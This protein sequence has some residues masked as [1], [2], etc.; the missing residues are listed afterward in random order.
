[1]GKTIKQVY[2]EYVA[3]CKETNTTL[4]FEDYLRMIM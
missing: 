2:D 1:M 3:W 4:S